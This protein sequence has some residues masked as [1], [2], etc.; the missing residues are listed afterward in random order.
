MLFWRHY[1]NPEDIELGKKKNIYKIGTLSPKSPLAD[2]FEIEV[3]TSQIC[4]SAFF[5]TCPWSKQEKIKL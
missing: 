2:N 3:L 1:A 4:S 5:P